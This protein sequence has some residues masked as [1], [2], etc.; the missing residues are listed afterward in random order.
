[1]DALK[2]LPN[3]RHLKIAFT[4]AGIPLELDSLTGLEELVIST[5]GL[6]A[7]PQGEILENVAKTI[8]QNPGITSIDISG[9]RR[10]GIS[11]ANK[12]QSLHQLFKYYPATAP[13]LHLRTLRLKSFLI[14]LDDVTLPHLTHLTSLGLEFIDDPFKTSNA[15]HVRYRHLL[16]ERQRYGSS[17]EDLWKALHKARICLQK[18]TANEVPSSFLGYLSSYSGLRELYLEPLDRVS[19]DAKAV[20]FFEG[21]LE[22]H[23]QSLQTLQIITRFENSWCFGSHQF[24][25]FSS[26]TGLKFLVMSIKVSNLDILGAH[27]HQNVP[28]SESKPDVIVS[29]TSFPSPVPIIMI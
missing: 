12:S 17:P 20:R 23:A 10:Y 29:T 19:S 26:L 21:G 22:N 25:T 6:T 9:I 15:Y 2:N 16:K 3:L 7:R 11:T 4:K 18:I 13:R 1:M 5:E 27:A 24:Q 14:R 8:A 28:P